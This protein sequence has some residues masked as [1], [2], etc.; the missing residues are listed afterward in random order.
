MVLML[1]LLE[2]FFIIVLSASRCHDLTCRSHVVDDEGQ[3]PCV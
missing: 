1:N 2:R 3:M